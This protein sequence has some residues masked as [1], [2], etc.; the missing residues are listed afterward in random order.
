MNAFI[1][2]VLKEKTVRTVRRVSGIFMMYACVSVFFELT[3]LAWG[4]LQI[5]IDYI[6][7]DVVQAQNSLVELGSI[8]EITFGASV[9]DSAARMKWE[10]L[11][12]AIGYF[13]GGDEDLSCIYVLPNTLPTVS[14]KVTIRVTARVKHEE[15]AT[16]SVSFTLGQRKLPDMPT[17]TPTLHPTVTPSPTPKIIPPTPQSA[18]PTPTPTVTAPHPATPMPDEIASLLAQAKECFVKERYTTPVHNNAFDY[19]K[20]VLTKS[21]ANGEALR[22][23][24]RITVKYRNLGDT[25]YSQNNFI[26]AE[27]FYK[28]YL[29][30][31]RY[32]LGISADS[33]LESESR[34]IQNRLGVLSRH[35]VPTPPPVVT[36]TPR[37]TFRITDVTVYDKR[38]KRITPWSDVYK[39]KVNEPV[40]ITVDFTHPYNHSI[41]VEWRVSGHGGR[42]LPIENKTNLYIGTKTGGDYLVITVRDKETGET[43]EKTLT[44]DIVLY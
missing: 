27:K 34:Y 26:K 5:E 30:V 40:R 4:Q 3:S 17:P 23:L 31:V 37:E 24:H 14:Q 36:S 42:V 10:I 33:T 16:D 19:Y 28:K 8:E 2:S 6:D 18:T 20:K 22:G 29:L 9:N 43:L 11:P 41:E 44:F 7:P 38:K 15:I 32:L 25:F 39:V 1:E 12:G 21:S 13:A 35:T